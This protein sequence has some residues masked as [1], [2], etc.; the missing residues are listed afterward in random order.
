MLRKIKQGRNS[1]RVCVEI[2]RMWNMKYMIKPVAVGYTG[3][4]TKCL[5]KNLEAVPGK[6]SMDSVHKTVILG[7]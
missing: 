5:K 1:S 4:A 7:T 3:I 6:H 2:Q